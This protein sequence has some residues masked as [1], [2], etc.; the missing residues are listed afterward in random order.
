M[1]KERKKIIK[2]RLG[3]REIT[4]EGIIY[5]SRGLIGFDDKRDFALIQI[6]ETSPF[7]LLQSLEDHT[8]GLVVADPYSFMDDY[9]VRLSDAEKRILRVESVGQIAVLVTVTIPPGRPDETTLNLG[10]PIV[11]NTEA[12]RGMQ[13]PQVDSKYPSHFRPA[14]EES[15]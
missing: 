10:G 3:E 4:E 11:V 12:K 15:S 9:E 6:S 5:F 2:T 1:A 14:N 7:L 8:L 13:V